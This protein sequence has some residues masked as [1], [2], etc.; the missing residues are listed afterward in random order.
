MLI[1]Q[2]QIIHEALLDLSTYDTF[3]NAET[4]IADIAKAA[5]STADAQKMRDALLDIALRQGDWK[6]ERRMIGIAQDAAKKLL[7]QLKLLNYA[8]NY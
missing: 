8:S 6:N 3:H 7:T 5:L 2:F 1:E 4:E